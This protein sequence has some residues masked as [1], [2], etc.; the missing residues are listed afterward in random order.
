MKRTHKIEIASIAG[1]LARDD[2]ELMLVNTLHQKCDV[3]TKA[4]AGPLW[5]NAMKLIALVD[6]F[7]IIKTS[8]AS[9]KIAGTEEVCL[10]QAIGPDTQAEAAPQCR[11]TRTTRNT[12]RGNHRGYHSSSKPTINLQ[13]IASFMDREGGEEITRPRMYKT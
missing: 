12:R 11:L 10:D 1:E 9:L 8:S 6:Q 7:S 3:F 5:G 4:V 13:N 2:V